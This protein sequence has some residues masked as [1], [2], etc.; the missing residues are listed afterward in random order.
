MKLESQQ[1]DVI[2]GFSLVAEAFERGDH[3]LNELIQRFAMKSM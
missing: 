2:L 1:A 3:F